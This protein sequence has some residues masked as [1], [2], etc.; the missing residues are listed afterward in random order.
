[1]TTLGGN[2]VKIKKA[3]LW[4]F[5]PILFACLAALVG[6]IVLSSPGHANM[7]H[8]AQPQQASGCTYGNHGPLRGRPIV[9]ASGTVLADDGCLL[10]GVHNADTT[11]CSASVCSDA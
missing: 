11:P 8:N 7:V 2:M 6:A 4:L 3:I 1:M 5:T 9:V 10:R